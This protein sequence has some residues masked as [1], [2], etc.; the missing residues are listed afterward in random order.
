MVGTPVPFLSSIQILTVL[1]KVTQNSVQNRQ[2]ALLRACKW[3]SCEPDSVNEMADIC[4]KTV[5]L[6][7]LV[8]CTDGINPLT[9]T[10]PLMGRA[11]RPLTKPNDPFRGAKRYVEVW[12]NFVHSYPK[13]CS[14][15]VCCGNPECQGTSV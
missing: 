1:H 9:P 5:H 12:R 13:Y 3:C 7:G 8:A 2:M 11:A 15:M 4:V 6:T 10:D 14:V